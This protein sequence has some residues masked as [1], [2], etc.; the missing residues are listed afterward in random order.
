MGVTIRCQGLLRYTYVRRF[1]AGP[2]Y[3]CGR[4]VRDERYGFV[5]NLVGQLVDHDAR[6]HGLHLT[7]SVALTS[8][9]RSFSR[10]T[11]CPGRS[12]F[13]IVPKNGKC[14]GGTAGRNSNNN[15]SIGFERSVNWIITGEHD[16]Q[17]QICL[18]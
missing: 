14:R 11:A 6:T 4:V 7:E 8:A 10:K 3:C 1:L 12:A 16:N 9:P 2:K 13:A 5:R 15:G 18:Q 17:D